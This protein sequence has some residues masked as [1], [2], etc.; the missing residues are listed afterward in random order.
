MVPQ[1]IDIK[2]YRG[3]YYITIQGEVFRRHCKYCV[4]PLKPY[5]KNGKYCVG[6]TNS[7]GEKKLFTINRLMKQSYFNCT[8][9]NYGVYHK[10]GLKADHSYWNLQL[11]HKTDLGKITGGQSK[12]KTVLKICKSTGDVLEIYKSARKASADNHVSHQTI[13]DYCNGKVKNTLFPNVTFVWED[14]FDNL[15][16]G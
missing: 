11:I 2:G 15:L 10:N 7:T 8:D 4:S 6:L 5:L 13:A 14:D 1:Q 16:Y 3:K 12:S 9:P